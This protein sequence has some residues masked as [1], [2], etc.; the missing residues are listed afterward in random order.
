M[1]D[2]GF[3]TTMVEFQTTFG[4]EEK[5]REYMFRQKWPEGFRCA[6]CG[7][8]RAWPLRHRPIWVCSACEYH[9]SLTVDT[10]LNGTRKPLRM[11]F[12]AMYLVTTSKRGISAKEL[13]RHLGCSYQTAWAWLHKLRAA[14][15]E[16][17]RRPLAGTVEVDEGYLGGRRTGKR[18]R[19]G[20]EMSL[21]VCA[22]E[23][24]G[25]GVGRIRLEVAADAGAAQLGAIVRRNVAVGERVVTDGW[26]GYRRLAQDGYDTVA[27]AI[28]GSGVEAHEV[29]PGVHRVFSLVKRWVLGTY[30]GSLSAKHLNSYL[31]EF[32][33]RFNRRRA[34]CPTHIF[35]R[36][37]ASACG[38]R[39][40]TYRQIV[41]RA[42][43]SRANSATA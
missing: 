20:P 36:L 3:P 32:T 22:A 37:A 9:A 17:G 12:L 23:R 29:L 6:R 1:L 33:F 5:C 8:R 39:C 11:W 14:M 30:Q 41:S 10:A 25:R 18:G 28:H 4:T 2:P 35:H 16:E 27:T 19:P 13:Q 21:L 42:L 15:V 7:G 24:V 26:C 40:P 43:A 38:R 34:Q 31:E